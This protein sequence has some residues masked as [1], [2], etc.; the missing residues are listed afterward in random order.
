VNNSSEA[1]QAA[2]I[3]EVFSAWDQ[4]RDTI[5]LIDFT[6]LH[7][8]SEA[9]ADAWVIEYGAGGQPWENAFKH[10]VWTLGL[11]YGDEVDKIALDRLDMEAIRR[12]W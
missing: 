2:F 8:V 6:W 4:Y 3:T 12:G 5:K 9:Q 7:D 11:R 10:Y 1:K